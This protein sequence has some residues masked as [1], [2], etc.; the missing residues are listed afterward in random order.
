MIPGTR[1]LASSPIQHSPSFFPPPIE[2]FPVVAMCDE[3]RIAQLS[4][5]KLPD[6]MV[7][8]AFVMLDKLPLTQNG[9]VDRCSLPAPDQRGLVL[10]ERFAATSDFLESKLAQI[11]ESLLGISPIGIRHNFFDLGGDSLLAA[12]LIHRIEE[13]FSKKLSIINVFEAPTIEQ[14]ATILRDPSSLSKLSRVVPIQPAGSR[15]PFFCIGAGPLFWPLAQRLGTD[16]PFLGLGLQESDKDRL[17]AP[18]TLAEI[19]G[20]L[21]KSMRELQPEGP[22][23]LGG[24]CGDG[25]IAYET[26]RQLWAQGQ[27]VA[28]LALFETQNPARSNV[29]RVKLLAQRLGFHFA[30]LWHLG[31]TGSPPYLRHQLQ[32]LLRKIKRLRWRT[33]YNLQLYLSN[34]RLRNLEQIL[35]VAAR[36]YQPQ[37]YPGCVVLFRCAERPVQPNWGGQSGWNELVAGG[38]E[39]YEIPGNHKTI[40]LEPNVDILASKLRTCLCRTQ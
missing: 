32:E 24:W 20:C 23:F 34:C 8:D 35:Y 4:Q 13:T 1:L 11:W 29:M 33:T 14:L 26:A 28:L 30:N 25:L 15:P 7:P 12:M 27:N 2:R 16:Q 3:K 31:I 17:R 40:F 22:Y 37:P 6:Y 5:K 21:V 9:K 18:Y 19:A 36:A 38:L 10:Q 39:V